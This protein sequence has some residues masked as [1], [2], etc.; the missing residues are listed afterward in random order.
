MLFFLLLHVLLLQSVQ[1]VILLMP[2]WVSVADWLR[3][4]AL[5]LR[6]PI[7]WGSNPMRGSCQ[8][9]TEGCWFTPRNNLFLQLWKLTS[10]Y[11]YND[12]VE[13]WREA[14]IHL[15]LMTCVS[16]E[17]NHYHY[18]AFVKR[19]CGFDPTTSRLQGKKS[20][21]VFYMYLKCTGI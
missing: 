18:N 14:P 21:I 13:Q 19:S 7:R 11:M 16:R 9:L 6:A 12:M 8:L 17:N 2:W 3:R 4:L 20:D 15:T 1:G 10:I 5:Q